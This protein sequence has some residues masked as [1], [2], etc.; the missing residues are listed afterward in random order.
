[1]YY[2]EEYYV[3]VIVINIVDMISNVFFGV[4]GVDLIFFKVGMVVDFSL[5]YRIDV[6]SIDNIVFMNVKI[7]VIEEGWFFYCI[8]I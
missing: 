3:I 6:F 1:M 2:G 5:V 4:V 8:V 7:C